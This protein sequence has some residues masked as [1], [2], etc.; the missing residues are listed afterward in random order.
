MY[1]YIV[2][3]H[4]PRAPSYG[5]VRTWVEGSQMS[6]DRALVGASNLLGYKEYTQQDFKYVWHRHLQSTN[7]V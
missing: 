6:G 1:Y 4:I 7:M 3:C 5:G 2:V